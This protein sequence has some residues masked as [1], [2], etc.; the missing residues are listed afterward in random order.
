MI[1]ATDIAVQFGE[2]PLYENVNLRLTA[3]N[4]YGFIGANGSGKSTFLKVISGDLEP[5][6]GTC[7]LDPGARLG[8]LR[9]DQFAYEDQRILDVVLQG[10]TE[11][12]DL[13]QRMDALYTKEDFSD[14]DGEQVAKLQERFDELDGYSQESNAAEVLTNLGIAPALHDR[15]MAAIDAAL[16]VRVLLAQAIFS[17][18]DVL[19]LDEPTNNLDIETIAWLE[20]FLADYE[21]C[22]CVVSHDRHFLN[23]V[24]THICDVDFRTIRTFVG[25][26]D[27]YQA[28]EQLAR[29]QRSKEQSRVEQQRDRLKTFVQRF[30]ANAARSKQATSRMKQLEALGSQRVI[31]SSRVSPR[32][33]FKQSRPS[34]Q[35]VLETEHLQF[36]WDEQTP[37]CSDLTLRVER[38]DRLAIVGRNGIGKTT[39]M[40]LF[41]GELEAQGGSVKRGNTL[42]TSYF[43][44]DAHEL[45][46]TELKIVDWLQQ[47][48][49]NQDINHMRAMLGRMLFSGDDVKKPVNVLSGGERVRCLLSMV[50][51]QEANTLF[52]DEPT[53][54]LDLEAIEALQE[55]L[56]GYQGT[57]LFVSH[58]RE[59]V[60]Q[61]ATRV[62]VLDEHG[63]T[64]WRGTYSDYRAS[65]GMV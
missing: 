4:C 3:G 11:V 63:I 10:H 13:Q 53:N 48:T 24:C 7:M 17:R 41:L 2:H 31:P 59:F 28:A 62:L 46:E 39:L 50:M 54:H 12:W 52:L 61:L 45:F 64:D 8:Q 44:Q 49:D 22:I 1:T 40:R 23:R 25:S 36:A 32:L 6:T 37:I 15:T 29:A 26:W 9:Q 5:N 38:G 27:V 19:L 20:Q 42:T 65:R 51:L 21:G 35:D 16:K 55:S 60:D 14:A 56:T 47:F 30:K 58:D 18:P 33:I 34:G 43:P 57:L